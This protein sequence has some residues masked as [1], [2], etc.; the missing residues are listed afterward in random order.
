VGSLRTRSWAQEHEEPKGGRNY[1]DPP[2]PIVQAARQSNQGACDQENADS[3][4][5]RRADYPRN[6]ERV[7]LFRV[8]SLRLGE[9]AHEGF[10]RMDSQM[11]S[12]RTGILLWPTRSATGGP[13][14]VRGEGRIT[15]LS[16][17]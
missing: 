2:A 15:T 12:V 9:F 11:G 8:F 3:A 13:F 17:S 16:G 5:N 6:R 10:I 14:G 7:P 1:P 4:K